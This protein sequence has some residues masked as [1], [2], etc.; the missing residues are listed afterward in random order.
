M[1]RISLV[2]LSTLVLPLSLGLG[3]ISTPYQQQQPQTHQ[4]CTNGLLF[5]GTHCKRWTHLHCQA[6]ELHGNECL[7]RIP[8]CPPP[9]QS[10]GTHCE[11]V[12]EPDP[13]AS[14][15]SGQ[16]DGAYPNPQ[17]QVRMLAGG[18][19][20]AYAGADKGA[21][22]AGFGFPGQVEGSQNVK[23]PPVSAATKNKI[24][25]ANVDYDGVCPPGARYEGGQ[26]IAIAIEN[27][28]PPG[29][30]F[31][32]TYCRASTVGSGGWASPINSYSY[33]NSNIN[34]NA[35]SGP[36]PG[37]ARS[38]QKHRQNAV[39]PPGTKFEAESGVCV[40]SPTS[41]ADLCPRGTTFD[42]RYCVAR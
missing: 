37:Y 28:C 19:P 40:H 32:G 23:P 2:A 8:V 25:N 21:A 31:D 20:P 41:P 30:S 12:M 33:S 34:I 18:Y 7:F 3:W 10:N 29:T 5:N 17:A 16:G 22:P 13:A 24:Y 27:P 15:V 39:C 9:L 38:G 6:P 14:G 11:F 35:G 36:G 1:P 42:G 26:C 4:K